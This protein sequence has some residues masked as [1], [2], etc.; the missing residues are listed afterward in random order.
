MRILLMAS[1]LL[2]PASALAQEISGNPSLY[3]E[4][5]AS[6]DIVQTMGEEGAPLTGSPAPGQPSN[7]PL[8]LQQ[9]GLNTVNL[10][11]AG[12]PVGNLTQRFS[13][14]QSINNSIV[15]G[16]LGALTTIS[17]SGSNSANTID[18]TTIDLAVQIMG[19][20][21]AQSV[22]NSLHVGGS[23][24]SIS[25]T[26]D[27]IA[28]LARAQYAIGVAVQD[29]YRD[30]VQIVSNR[31]DLVEGSRVADGI[32]QSGT[33]VGN[34]LIAE[35]VDSVIRRFDG[36]QI[37]DN[38][39][40]LNDGYRPHIIQSGNNIANF[41]SAQS[42][43]TIQQ[44]STGTQEIHNR[45]LGPDGQEIRHANIEQTQSNYMGASNVVNLMLVAPASGGSVN[46][47]DMTITQEAAFD[48]SAN[49]TGG[50][51]QSGNVLIVNR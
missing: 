50:Q 22:N 24:A 21:A 32:R 15:A 48:Q 9:T 4:F 6:Q 42:V 23:M 7:V 13:G 40:I 28:N 51:S 25:Q 26:G 41:I 20:G 45:V 39:V 33:N 19:P 11:D 3:Q 30:S 36:T 16:A 2:L 27:N 31:L 49:G 29:I 18:G 44:I 34:M 43:G 12:Q 14:T 17:Q 5:T 37:V 46:N 8:S 38:T 47:D 10:V 1:V 35:K